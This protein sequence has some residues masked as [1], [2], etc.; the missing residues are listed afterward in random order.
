MK[1]SEESPPEESPPCEDYVLKLEVVPRW[2]QILLGYD[3]TVLWWEATSERKK[4]PYFKRHVAPN[5]CP[6]WR[7]LLR[8]QCQ[9]I[10]GQVLYAGTF[11][12]EEIAAEQGE[13]PADDHC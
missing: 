12:T 7:A 3:P 1:Q 6:W 9:C 10:K 8:L 4:V 2:K 11:S 13:Q 5:D